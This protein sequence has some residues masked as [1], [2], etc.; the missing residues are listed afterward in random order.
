MFVVELVEGK[1][2]PRQAGPLEFEDLSR[3]TLGLLLR[4]MKSYFATG[5]Y[6]IL[7]YSLCVLK[8]LIQLRKKGIFPCDVINKRRCWPAMVRIKEME[9]HYREMEVGDTYSIQG[10]VDDVIYNLW[11]KK[12]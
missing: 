8:G 5:R 10:T 6:V 11:G 9:D 12:V 7:D 2:H 4:M 1:E 3:N